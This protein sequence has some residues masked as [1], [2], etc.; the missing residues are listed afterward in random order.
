MLK[1]ENVCYRYKSGDRD[2][3]KNLSYEFE[4]GKLYSIIGPSGTGKTTLLSI[5][6]GLARPTEGKLYVDDWDLTEI[7]LNRY[8]REKITM[9]F[10]SFHLF[11]LLTALE[12]VSYL[13]ETLG[14]KRKDAEA[15][16]GELL[17]IVG[18]SED[19]Y[20]RYPA[21]L[22]GGEQQRVAIARSLSTGAKLI[23]ADEPTGN[24]DLAN[25]DAIVSILQ[26]LAYKEEYC[27]IVVTHNTAIA[28]ASDVVLH[29]S[30]GV[31]VKTNQGD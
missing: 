21:N 8:R 29:M 2:I 25:S 10:Q 1:L 28:D 6:A 14:I 27:V 19:K 23:L 31:I 17:N 9:I 11:P 22:S 12:N 13:M 3:L 5:I 20:K 26:N 7:N 18:I 24:L 4:M 15:R 16:A 30:D